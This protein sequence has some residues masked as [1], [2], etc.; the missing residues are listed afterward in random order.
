MLCNIT[1][2]NCIIN[3]IAK[4]T[5]YKTAVPQALSL[6]CTVK[7]YYGCNQHMLL[8]EITIFPNVL[9]ALKKIKHSNKHTNPNVWFRVKSKSKS[10]CL[11]MLRASSF[12]TKVFVSVSLKRP[13]NIGLH[14][15]LKSLM[16]WWKSFSMLIADITIIFKKKF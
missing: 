2:L 5:A 9:A 14:G 7:H 16:S 8:N 4:S 15:R 13:T 1:F 3:K 12:S 6:I 11:K 10:T